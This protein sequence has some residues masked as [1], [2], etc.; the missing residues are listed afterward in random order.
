MGTDDKIHNAADDALGH[1]KEAVGD[2]T[3][4]DRLK[5]EGKGDQAKAHLGKAA[6]NV[7]DAVK[8]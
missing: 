4:N 5:A 8:G 2:A 1:A 6:E 3:D 7:K